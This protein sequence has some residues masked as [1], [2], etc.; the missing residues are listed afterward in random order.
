MINAIIID[1]EQDAV[2]SMSILLE[3]FCKSVTL[4]GTANTLVKGIQEIKSKSPDLV[5]MDVAMPDGT[6]FDILDCVA[7]MQFHTIFVTA[8]NEYAIKAI[9]ANAFDY[10][11]KP[12]D[13]E[14]LQSSITRYS[15]SKTGQKESPAQA[16]YSNLRIPVST[17][18]GCY[19]LAYKEII[20]LKAEGSYTTIYCTGARPIV[21][22]KNLKEFE[23]LLLD[24]GFYRVHNSHIVNIEHIQKYVR[25]DGGYLIM[26]DNSQ[27][28]ISKTR[29]ESFLHT[30]GI[31]C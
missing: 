22:S 25:T 16:G 23:H 13:I 4:I 1:D 11:L 29:K 18:E 19:Y 10:L 9:K 26:T 31:S 7:E 2:T 20:H 28:E 6:G 17:Q 14:E 3:E 21:V 15:K 27:V 12:V 5:F 30:I 8:F 24:K